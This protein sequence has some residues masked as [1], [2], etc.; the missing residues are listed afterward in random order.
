[1]PDSVETIEDC[2]FDYCSSLENVVLSKNLTEI[3][4]GLFAECEK[5][6]KIT[7][8]NSIKRIG[9]SAFISCVSLEEIVFEGT[10]AQWNAIEKGTYWNRY[11]EN[12]E[13]VFAKTENE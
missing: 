5:L 3:S 7:L 6:T 9:D 12:A 8:P 4:N 13:I 2:A 1:M 10:E 11:S